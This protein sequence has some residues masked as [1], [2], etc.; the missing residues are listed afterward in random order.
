[1]SM[2]QIVLGAILVALVIGIVAMAKLH[3]RM[4]EIGTEVRALRYDVAR[5][6]AT[7]ADTGG[8]EPDTERRRR[9]RIVP[10]LVGGAGGAT[11]LSRA[12]DGARSHP[13]TTAGVTSAA[14]LAIAAAVL[15]PA[16]PPTFD[17]GSEAGP[18]PAETLH[19]GPTATPDEP[20]PT[21]DPEPTGPGESPG[22]EPDEPRPTPDPGEDDEAAPDDDGPML[23][24][25]DPSPLPSEPEPS[26]QPTPDEPTDPAPDP[27]PSPTPDDPTEPE[28]PDDTPPP[29]DPPPPDDMNDAEPLPALFCLGVHLSPVVELGAC[30][31]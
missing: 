14:V 21:P 30:L 3:R 27:D 18:P 12:R 16:V 26:P 13:I 23:P 7:D 10:A 9:L 8:S 4:T 24:I 17:G 15:H 19:P 2:A 20:E 31:L 6:R 28:P 29:E 25:D 11:L 1:M 5:I 22:D